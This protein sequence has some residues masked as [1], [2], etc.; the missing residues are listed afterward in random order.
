MKADNNS[1]RLDS[2]SQLPK[3]VNLVVSEMLT[4]L[5]IEQL[6]Q[7]KKEHNAYAKEAFSRLRPK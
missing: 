1:E 4:P 2:Q 6:K 7:E 5:E 3:A